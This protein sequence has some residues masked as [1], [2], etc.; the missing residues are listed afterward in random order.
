MLHHDRAGFKAICCN[1]ADETRTFGAQ[2]F[3]L[4][5]GTYR[6]TLG[7]D[8]NQDD[9]AERMIREENVRIE[10]GSKLTFDLE[11]GHEYILELVTVA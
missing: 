5:P 2:L 1:V 3:E 4:E 8:T 11:R 9:K 10:R 6:L 7:I